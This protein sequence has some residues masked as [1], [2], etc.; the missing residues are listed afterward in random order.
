L[1]RSGKDKPPEL[2][3]VSF[4]TEVQEESHRGGRKRMLWA[5]VAA[6]AGLLLL[7]LLGPDEQE[8]KDRFEYY[9]APGELKIMPE[10]SIEEGHHDVHQIPRSL[11]TQPPP[12]NIE[13]EKEDPTEDGTVEIPPVNIQEPN[14]SEIVSELPRED[15]EMSSDPQVKMARPMQSNPDYYILNL[16]YPEYPLGVSE[17]ER[18]IP[19]I[20]VNVN[21]FVGP[22][23]L[24]TDAWVN[25]TNG[26]RLFVEEGIK[27]AKQWKFG[28]RVNPGIG[29]SYVIPW[30][31]KS[32]Y[33]TPQR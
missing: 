27:A 19:V 24:V 15:S 9:G 13:I 33:F 4:R 25:S 10:I 14:T 1:I 5:G 18:R 22:D 12:S 2:L 17:A 8:I 30:Q 7:V 23:G 21:I 6:V 16:V 32:P 11:M 20:Y 28:W 26:S 29:R 31:F 3:P